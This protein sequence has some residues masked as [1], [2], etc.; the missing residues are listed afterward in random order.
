MGYADY[1]RSLGIND[2]V[3]KILDVAEGRRAYDKMQADSQA[4]LD[5][6]AAKSREDMEAYRGTM[7]QWYDEKVLPDMNAARAD[8]T[9]ARADEA[10]A[11]EVVRVASETNE[12][13]RK[14]AESMGWKF[15]AAGGGGTSPAPANQPP[16]GG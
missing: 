15:D 14:V 2:E 10:R 4:A 12:G 6:A 1:L 9:R 16:A 3:I 8:A 7:Q 13:L 5:A 11:R